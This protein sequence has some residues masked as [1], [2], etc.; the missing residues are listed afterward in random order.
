MPYMRPDVKAHLD[1]AQGRPSVIDISP[2]EARAMGVQNAPIMQPPARVMRR[3]DVVV[4]SRGAHGISARIY[5]PAETN[6]P[7]PVMV[8]YHGGGWVLGSIEGS[9]SLCSEIAYLM[10]M[11]LVSVGYRLG[12]EHLYPA[13]IEDSIDVGRWVASSPDAF[14]CPVSGLILA[15]DSAGGSLAATVARELLGASPIPVLAQWLIY[16]MTD[17]SINYPS[18]EDKELSSVLNLTDEAKEKFYQHY[19]GVDDVENKKRDP[20]VSPLLGK[21]WRGLPPAVVFTC[22]VDPLRDQGRAYAAKLASEG[23]ETIFY[24]AEGQIHGC[25]SMRKLLPSA[26]DDLLK[27]IASLKLLVGKALT[28]TSTG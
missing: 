10:G 18:D 11:T 24:E 16:P 20:R 27:G 5:Y 21:T 26:Q 14:G 9:D 15:G 22:S 12:P 1:A 7:M 19:F 4:P 28:P 8:Y 17:I 2:A 13:A 3:R 25:F 23:I 6:G